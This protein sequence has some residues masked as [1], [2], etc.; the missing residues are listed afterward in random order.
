MAS[1]EEAVSSAAAVGSLYAMSHSA[2][3]TS[4]PLEQTQQRQTRET[5]PQ[6]P[7]NY[8]AKTTALPPK[9]ADKE[10]CSR[11]PNHIKG[12]ILEMARRNF[13]APDV[14]RHV[15]A[16]TKRNRIKDMAVIRTW[17]YKANGYKGW[18][19]RTKKKAP[20]PTFVVP[21]S[22]QQPQSQSS[23]APPGYVPAASLH[24]NNQSNAS[25]HAQ[26]G[27]QYM[28]QQLNPPTSVYA[29][30]PS[31]YFTNPSYYFGPNSRSAPPCT[32]S[33]HVSSG[34]HHI[35]I[36]TNPPSNQLNPPNP[37]GLFGGAHPQYNSSIVPLPQMPM[38]MP[39][40]R[41]PASSNAASVAARQP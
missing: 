10:I 36:Y 9:L 17:L 26:P 1:M 30:A 16:D 4:Q 11:F 41:G 23:T 7:Q 8:P 34:T 27:F 31:P 39:A 3:V 40:P 13:F 20:R 18:G 38:L 14:Y 22:S 28:Q 19:L 32:T 25:Y 5:F 29:P 2:P 21:P 24:V 12:R 15:P 33:G 6:N 37:H 35:P